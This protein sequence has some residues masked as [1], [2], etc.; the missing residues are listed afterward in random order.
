MAGEQKP[1]TAAE[2]AGASSEPRPTT[3]LVVDDSAVDRRIAGRILE[4]RE[5]LHVEYARDGREALAVI[6][7]CAPAVVLTDL[8]M[9]DL[10]G[11][12]LVQ[13][14]RQRYSSIPV[15]LMT[16]HGSEEIAMEALHAGASNYVPKRDLPRVLLDTLDRV[17]AVAQHA[18]RRERLMAYLQERTSY[19]R[20]GNEP[21][22]IGPLI[23]L[24]QQELDIAGFCD[25]TTRTR[26]GIAL[27][28]ALTNALYHGNLEV[29]SDLR[30]E[31]ENVFYAEAR[32][33]RFETPYRDRT[34]HI[35]AMLNREV[36]T[37]EIEDEGPGFDITRIDHPPN[38]EDIMRIGGRGLLLIR[39]FMDE[40]TFT[41]P[42]N[43]ITMVLK[44]HK[45]AG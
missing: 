18:H 36:A 29:S 44:R 20:L 23:H 19:F 30:Q 26:V 35:R 33:R 12:E 13:E 38:P 42:G 4:K 24:C 9:P 17:L 2:L 8:Q 40:V 5:D 32:R 25:E 1:A 39:T 28:E 14:I 3:I 45:A 16:A 6:E 27:T 11:L 22:L 10:N 43:R 7:Q 37:Y 21:E 41:P 34:I 31:D 15:M